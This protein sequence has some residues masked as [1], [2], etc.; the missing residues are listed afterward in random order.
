MCGLFCC[1]KKKNI[2]ERH[3]SFDNV[4]NY[5]IPKKAEIINVKV[6]TD[7]E[8][9]KEV[10]L[11][12][13]S[14][15]P[16]YKC[17]YDDI[18]EFTDNQIEWLFNANFHKFKDNLPVK[19]GNENYFKSL[20]LKIDKNQILFEKW[21]KEESKYE[22]IKKFWKSKYNISD[23]AYDK[24][25][26]KESKLNELFSNDITKEFIDIIEYSP[27][28][29][30]DEI[31]RDLKTKDE[32]FLSLIKTSEKYKD[33]IYENLSNEDKTNQ[34]S[35]IYLEKLKDIIN[36]L[37]STSVEQI[38]KEILPR[39]LHKFIPKII[40]IVKNK[41]EK[42]PKNTYKISFETIK[43]LVDKC[44]KG[45]FVLNLMKDMKSYFSDP[46]VAIRSVALSFLN[47]YQNILSFKES[48]CQYQGKNQKFVD[49]LKNIQK[50]F[51]DHIQE[52][53]LFD[54]TMNTNYKEA[55]ELLIKIGK[56]VIKDRNKLVAL[57]RE[58]EN[59][60]ENL[61]VNNKKNAAKIVGTV[62]GTVGCFM[63]T[64]ATGGALGI[65]FLIGTA[66][67][68]TAMGL[69][70]AQ[71]VKNKKYIKEFNALLQKAT[72]NYNEIQ[73]LIKQLRKKYDMIQYN[74][75]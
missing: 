34:I 10:L 30:S 43:N 15:D 39:D 73:E 6:K 51:K 25:N 32:D 31:L 60:I 44:S 53:K 56:N 7:I 47:L 52:I 29:K 8:S 20:V 40:E 61:K 28:A 63:G 12:C 59:E 62:V 13:I 72:E 65:F 55:E 22:Y 58:I 18:D 54:I 46:L 49:D 26:E 17:L 9:K 21:Y 57:I 37:T 19:T 35:K 11:I 42:E 27:E 67:N 24:E 45:N 74:I 4:N 2:R 41:I 23:L 14:E 68:I 66:A 48:N 69:N 71:H 38:A 75:K 3:D 1:C 64:F 36:K 5:L 70:S 50:E 16:K 33:N